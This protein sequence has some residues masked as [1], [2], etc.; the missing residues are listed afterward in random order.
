MQALA[1]GSKGKIS[2]APRAPIELPTSEPADT[3]RV[4]KGFADS[5][6]TPKTGYLFVSVR[7]LKLEQREEEGGR[8]PQQSSNFLLGHVRVL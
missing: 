5:F 8:G 7:L 3:R 6:E 1:A 4:M 2:L